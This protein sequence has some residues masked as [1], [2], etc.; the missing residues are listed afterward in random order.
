MLRYTS[1][2][3]KW[4][5]TQLTVSLQSA[6]LEALTIHKENVCTG[7]ANTHS[8]A[9]QK[10]ESKQVLQQNSQTSGPN[11]EPTNT[12]TKHTQSFKRPAPH[13]TYSMPGATL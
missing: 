2:V 6:C 5:T 4:G 11:V 12:P 7:A 1:G 3:R 10:P 9:S 13:E 8:H